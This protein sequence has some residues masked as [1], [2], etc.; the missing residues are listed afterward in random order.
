MHVDGG[1]T[2]YHLSILLIVKLVA[3]PSCHLCFKI[4]NDLTTCG[5]VIGYKVCFLDLT[6]STLCQSMLWYG[7]FAV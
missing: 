1:P 7:S 4:V 3:S 6:K 5:H 2:L